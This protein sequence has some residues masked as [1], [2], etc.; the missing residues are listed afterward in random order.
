MLDRERVRED[1]RAQ[2]TMLRNAAK[3]KMQTNVAEYQPK[4]MEMQRFLDQNPTGIALPAAQKPLSA[5]PSYPIDHETQKHVFQPPPMRNDQDRGRGRPENSRTKRLLEPSTF[6]PTV[7]EPICVLKIELDG[8]N[9]EEIKVFEN[10]DPNQIVEEF[11]MKFNLSSNAKRRLL[12]QINDQ[13]QID[14]SSQ[15]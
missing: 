8:Q 4:P 11:G 3:H 2:E 13:I 9:V 5:V 6:L 14:D 12:D 1:P 7:E 10:D 15:Y